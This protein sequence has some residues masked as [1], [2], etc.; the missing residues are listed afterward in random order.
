MIISVIPFLSSSVSTYISTT[1]LLGSDSTFNKS[2]KSKEVI[3]IKI[4]KNGLNK[5][6]KI[7]SDLNLKPRTIFVENV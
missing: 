7:N 3:C 5:I 4:F 2:V 1:L 6:G